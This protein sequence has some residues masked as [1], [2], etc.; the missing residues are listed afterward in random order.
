MRQECKTGSKA[1]IFQVKS[2][3]TS[4]GNKVR[5]TKKANNLDLAWFACSFYE[6]GP[7]ICFGVLAD[8]LPNES[9]ALSKAKCGFAFVAKNSET[10]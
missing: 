8:K 4:I 7:A 6:K 5:L 1:S 2:N 3:S 10:F 9:L